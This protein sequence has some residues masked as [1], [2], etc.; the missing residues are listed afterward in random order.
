MLN[1]ETKRR[2]E[3]AA[4]LVEAAIEQGARLVDAHDLD[5]NA[6]EVAGEILACL[7]APEFEPQDVAAL[8]ANAQKSPDPH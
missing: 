1:P 5:V 7:N 6:W 2:L 8:W 4:A 3:T